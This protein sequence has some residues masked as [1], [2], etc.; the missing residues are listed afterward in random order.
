MTKSSS[1]ATTDLSDA[2]PALV[3]HAAPV[4]RDYGGRLAFSGPVA[5]LHAPGDNSKVR[6][7]VETKGEGRVLVVDGEGLMDCAL[8]GGNLGKLAEENGWAGVVV[9]GCVRDTAELALCAI[10]V[11]A[12]AAHPKRSEKRGLGEKDVVLNFAGLTIA[13]GE[14]LYADGDGIIVS[15]EKIG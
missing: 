6:E 1:P 11:K 15:A 13:P 5:T 8:F 2:H 10:G 7:A 4:F 9:N 3:R 14:W 12:L